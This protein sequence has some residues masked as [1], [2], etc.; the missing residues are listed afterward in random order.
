MKV[1]DVMTYEVVTVSPET[2]LKEVA[3]TLV[4]HG[5]SGVPVVDAADRVLGVV[6]EG[7]VLFKERGGETRRGGP[8]KWMLDGASYANSLKADALTAREAMTSPAVTISSVRSV[9]EAARRMT[10]RGVNRLPVVENG[11][12]AGIVTRADLVRAFVRSDEEISQEINEDVFERALWIQPETLELHVDGGVV[13]V[14]GQVEAHSDA[15]VLEK[16]IQRV[17]GVVSLASEVTW[18]VDDLVRR[19]VA[20]M[21]KRI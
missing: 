12:L 2:S 8:L 21:P 20:A 16:L 4:Q 11:V 7:D 1:K 17:P 10:D 15:R 14:R 3:A 5:I 9:S 19:P 13:T 6:S 18:R